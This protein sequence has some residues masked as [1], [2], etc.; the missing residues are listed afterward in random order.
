MSLE[1]TI[2]AD[3]N[4]KIGE[5][6]KTNGV[7]YLI[8]IYND[9][10]SIEI[11]FDTGYDGKQL[12]N[13]AGKLNKDLSKVNNIIL[14][15][16]HFDHTN[17]LSTVLHSNKNKPKIYCNE[18]IFYKKILNYNTPDARDIGITA[19]NEIKFIQNNT[20]IQYIKENMEIFPGVW[21]ISNIPRNIE[22]NTI[23][24]NLTNV[25]RENP[26]GDYITDP[27]DEDSS[28]LIELNKEELFLIIGCGHSGIK[29]TIKHI[30]D[31]FNGKKIIGIVGGL[32][33]HDKDIKQIE[34][35]YSYINKLNLEYFCPIH[36]TG[37][38][39]ISL[40]KENMGKEF[41][42]GGVGTVISI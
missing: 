9:E 21:T 41:I 28:L 5:E 10:N 15:H 11:L 36:S 12:I 16:G 4:S 14:S 40:F 22:T 33:L 32:Q 1:L 8:E 26:D 31:N 24:G 2:L 39:A 27:I 30:N 3:T 7:S 37:E 25:Y 18:N 23:S 38:T 19:N 20:N 17:G 29:N 13:I 42:S 35:V 34:D 6:Y